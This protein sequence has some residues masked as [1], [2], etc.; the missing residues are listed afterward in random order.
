[1]EDLSKNLAIPLEYDCKILDHFGLEFARMDYTIG[2]NGLRSLNWTFRE[3]D[4]SLSGLA[5]SGSNLSEAE[6]LNFSD[7]QLF[8]LRMALNG[9]FAY[10]PQLNKIATLKKEEI[11]SGFFRLFLVSKNF[12]KITWVHY[13]SVAWP[14]SPLAASES[15]IQISTIDKSEISATAKLTGQAFPLWN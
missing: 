14:P 10:G 13:R 1:M 11:Q 7:A 9:S 6:M 3:K 8:S 4:N 12:W 5:N 2:V 15:T